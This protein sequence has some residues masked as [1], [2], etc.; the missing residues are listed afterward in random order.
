MTSITISSSVT[1]IGVGAFGY[2]NELQDV[3]YCGDLADWCNIYFESGDTSTNP[4]TYADNLYINGKLLQGEL[5]IPK[6]LTSIGNYTFAGFSSLTSITIPDS[7]T[8]IGEYAFYDC[9]SLISITIPDSV[10]DIGWGA[11]CSCTKLT[12]V[13]IGRG[14]TSIGD[15]AFE[16]CSGLTDVYYTG[17]IAGWCNISFSDSYSNPMSYAENLYING[18]LL[19]GEITISDDVTSIGSYAFYN[20][21]RLT[22]VTIGNSVTSI[23]YYAF[24]GCCNI[25]K[26]TIPTIAIDLIPK[27]NLQEVIIS[28]GENIGDN[29][30]YN[31]SNLTSVTIDYGVTSIGKYAFHNCSNLTNI[32]ILSSVNS[33]GKYAFNNCSAEIIWGENL[34]ITQIGEYA[35]A[36]YEGASLTIPSSVES[37][38]TGAFYGCTSLKN[39]YHTGDIA[40]WCNISFGSSDANPIYYAEN[41]YIEGELIQGDLV[42][43]DSV[44]G[45]GSF[46]FYGCT[47]L[48]SI[49]IP[50]SVTN[51]GEWA[52]YDCSGLV[53]VYY[54]GDIAG[55]CNIV[56]FNWSSTPM[57]YASNLYINGELIQG[58]LIIPNGVTSIEDAVFW[59]C[60]GLT[61]IVI[62]NSIE[63][64]RDGAF[65]GCTGLTD[66]YYT[67]DMADWCNISFGSSDANPMY[68][69]ENLYINGEL[70]QKELVI[71]DGVTG[72]KDY[73]FANCSSLTS[74]VIPNSVG[75]IGLGAFYGCTGLTSIVIPDSLESIGIM[76]FE[77]CS[78]LTDVYYTGDVA[79]WCNI[80]FSDCH[81]NPMCYAENLY[82]NGELLQGELII[83]DSVTS[84]GRYAFVHCNG[85]TS[86]TIGNSVTSIGY[87]AFYN[88]SNLIDV[89]YTGDIAGWC[90]ISFGDSYANP[91]NY[92][93]N[94]HINGELIQGELIV[95][96]NVTSIGYYAFYKCT[97]LTSIT[98]PDSVESIG[99]CAFYG[100]TSLIIYCEVT[101]KPSGWDSDWNSS[102]CPIV[103]D[104]NNN[105][106]AEDGY[107][108]IMIEGLKYGILDN[109]ATVSRYMVDGDVIIPSEIEYG[110]ITYIVTGIGNEAFYNCAYLTSIVIPDIVTS[111]GNEAFYNCINLTSI[112]IPD[113][114]TSVGSNSF[115]DCTSLTIYCETS[116]QPSGWNSAWNYSNGPVVWDCNN[117]EIATDGYQYVVMDGIRYRIK[118]N[119]AQVA[120]CNVKGNIIIP[121]NIEIE[122]LTYSVTSIGVYAFYNCTGLTSIVIPDSVIKIGPS[123][124]YNCTSLTDVY[125]LGDIVGWCNIPFIDSPS[126][127]KLYAENLYINGELLQGD[128]IIPD[129]VTSIGGEAFRN[130]TGLTSIVIPDS[131]TNIGE[132]A[133]SG[134]SGLTSIVIPDSVTRIGYGA[135]HNCTGL[136]EIVIPDRVTS[137]G[138]DAFYGCSGLVEV[139]FENTQGWQ[140]STSSNFSSYTELSSSDLADTTIAATYLKDTYRNYYWRRVE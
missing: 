3:Y 89:Y 131:V 46:A 76:A 109:S 88:C 37:I 56:G 60:T 20:C 98:I 66:I 120:R 58:D 44:T 10:T 117:N 111:I 101:F 22:S 18:E 136:T 85:L 45:I 33:I 134:C 77:G 127:P 64:I 17:D 42:I 112:V 40:S 7:V 140:V 105:N 80:S 53:N 74:I 81:A 1:S 61:S 23:G 14:V 57:E 68:Y 26:A 139:N 21:T 43:P 6:G 55:W 29:A 121:S 87:Y 100:C 92:A 75:S 69:A 15:V 47:S 108:Y 106:T 49:T 103:W 41:L 67:G 73:A 107:Q 13:T 2:C 83:P 122:G 70:I 25:T 96:D 94:L 19:Q 8:S 4:M 62:P 126:N 90:N 132:Y 133:F 11:F 93:E 38:G 137:I 115:E 116:S 78:G 59:G 31:C 48:T 54:T 16:G 135:F 138:D 84:I 82:I 72:I 5:I 113:S 35:F 114:V 102:N 97:G 119:V 30:F 125:Y 51:I 110:G 9:S 123:A 71:P 86:V 124:F 27:D 95:P 28:G 65:Y 52:F 39:V 50:D 12:S 32:I 24:Y 130:C 104:C 118:D 129:N 34:T 36:G 63:N 79:G 99:T 128:L 91:M